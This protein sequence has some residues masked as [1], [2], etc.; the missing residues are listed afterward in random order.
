M[1]LSGVSLLLL[2]DDRDTRELFARSLTKAG[3]DVRTADTAEHALEIL[4]SWRPTAVICDLH[5]PDVDGY[6]F[7][8]MVRA[9]AQLDGLPLI[10]ISAS[11]PSIERDKSLDAGFAAHLSKPSKLSD[12]IAAVS[13]V[14]LDA[15]SARSLATSTQ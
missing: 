3:A 7:L 9:R 6:G 10:A 12:I 1:T 8:R 11:H 2:E 4:E 15:D 5:L 14:V 13:R